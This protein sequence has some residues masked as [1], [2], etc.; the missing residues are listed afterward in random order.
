MLSPSGHQPKSC[1]NGLWHPVSWQKLKS[2][3]ATLEDSNP[4]QMK[5]VDRLQLQDTT[6]SGIATSF[7]T[8]WSTCSIWYT[9]LEH[10]GGKGDCNHM[11]VQTASGTGC[12]SVRKEWAVPYLLRLVG[13]Y[14]ADQ[15][16]DDPDVLQISLTLC[17]WKNKCNFDL[18]PQV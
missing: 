3:Q 17:A 16:L 8:A 6:L 10:N 5:R 13:W 14:V 18:K 7:L 9:S 12:E 2:Q 11:L 4:S 15:G 1:E